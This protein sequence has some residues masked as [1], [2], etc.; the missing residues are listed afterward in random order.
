MMLQFDDPARGR[1]V[2]LEHDGETVYAYLL[3]AGRIV[4]HVWLYNSG[5]HQ[6]LPV[7]DPAAWVGARQL[8]PLDAEERWRADFDADG[9][10]I[11]CDGV[12]V[13]KLWPGCKPGRSLLATGPLARPPD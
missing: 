6:A 5:P 4:G 2:M 11:F 10:E 3:E 8:P 7:A 1:R 9:A 12:R 13:A